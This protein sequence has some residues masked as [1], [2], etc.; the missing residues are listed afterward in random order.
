ME[1]LSV[2]KDVFGYSEFRGEQAAIID[3]VL[4]KSNTLVIMPTGMGKSLCYQLPCRILGGLTLV[5]SPLI[6]L[7]KDQVD[8]VSR[9]GI[10]AGF[11]NSSLERNSREKAYRKLSEK[12]YEVLYVTPER[13]RKSDFIEALKKNEIKLLAIDEAHCISE[14]G[15]D[16]RPDYSR[17]GEI[18]KSL[19]T[20]PTMAL[21]AT[22][23]PDVRADIIKQLGM[24][25]NLKIFMD[26][27]QRPNLFVKMTD[28][29]GFESKLERFL[30][31]RKAQKGAMIL[32]FSLVGTLQE[33]SSALDKKKI[34]HL[35]YHGQ[36]PQNIR[37]SN[38]EKFLAS[39]D[40]LI[41]ATPAF[42]LG[43]NKENIRSVVHG[44]LPG[45]IESY[46]QEIGRAGRDGK[47]AYCELLYDQD[48]ITI[49]M[50][51]IKWSNP[52][53]SFIKSTFQLVKNN[54]A[55][56]K[57]EGLDYLRGQL[58][59]YNKRDYRVETA[60]NLL[61]RWDCLAGNLSQREIEVLEEPSG[62]FVDKSLFEKR[63]RNQNKKLLDL[64][65]LVKSE[66]CRKKIIYS[67]FGTESADCGNCDNCRG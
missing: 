52:D 10:R 35:T 5:I 11:I 66:D 48:D 40:G 51:F 21:T 41:L 16:F 18:R 32:Y 28:L 64:V 15:N 49:Q 22:A 47:E 45:S 14:W 65:Q 23:T 7:M 34:P 33:F 59:F 20:P 39:E 6:A 31:V 42:G 24:S 8:Q 54:M 62:D 56:F 67:Y 50:D 57:Q 58:N 63:I 37:R 38:Q 29:H 26:G 1:K 13:F 19:G 44:E 2:L 25:D 60:L 17:L 55:R 46:Y 43:V 4:S 3:S 53:P 30:E 9:L 27:I 36:L 12:Q 61:E